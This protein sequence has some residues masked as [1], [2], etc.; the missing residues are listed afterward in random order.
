ML[1]DM[2]KNSFANPVKILKGSVDVMIELAKSNPNVNA[3][4]LKWKAQEVSQKGRNTFSNC[5]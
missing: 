4:E 2:E 1:L 3:A 5:D